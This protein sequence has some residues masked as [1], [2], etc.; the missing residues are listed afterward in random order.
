MY[1]TEDGLPQH[2]QR[3]QNG[4]KQRPDEQRIMTPKYERMG[5]I[6]IAVSGSLIVFIA[7]L[8]VI[9]LVCCE[10]NLDFGTWGSGARMAIPTAVCLML[11]GSSLILTSGVLRST[12]GHRK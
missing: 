12:A 3:F 2:M 7:T 8:A 1:I 4:S 6:L 10:G 5:G 11:V 9:D